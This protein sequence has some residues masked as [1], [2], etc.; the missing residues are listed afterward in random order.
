[1]DSESGVPEEVAQGAGIEGAQVVDFV[2]DFEEWKT[3]FDKGRTA[4][5]MGPGREAVAQ[6]EQ[7][8]I[9]PIIKEAA[10]TVQ[11]LR[12]LQQYSTLDKRGPLPPEMVQAIDLLTREKL[13]ELSG[14]LQD[15]L[16]PQKNQQGGDKS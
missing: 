8:G 11:Y 10:V 5:R 16:N 7:Q 3:A 15:F 13:A 1:M 2:K 12:A 14:K 9:A 6:L 4:T